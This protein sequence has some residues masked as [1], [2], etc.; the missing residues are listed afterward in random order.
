M[1]VT[2]APLSRGAQIRPPGGALDPATPEAQDRPLFGL[3]PPPK[4]LHEARLW[5]NSG[6]GD[7]PLGVVQSE[8][9]PSGRF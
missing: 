5:P 7:A 6:L 3:N 1:L 4:C 8:V 2:V 9:T